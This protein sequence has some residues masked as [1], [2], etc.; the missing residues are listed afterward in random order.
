MSDN[1]NS[2]AHYARNGLQPIDVIEDWRLSFN[3][4]NALKYIMRAGHKDKSKLN[5]DYDKAIFYLKRSI[6]N[7]DRESTNVRG[8]TIA[9]NEV[10]FSWKDLS[11]KILQAVEIIYFLNGHISLYGYEQDATYAVQLI[12]ESKST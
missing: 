4:G 8:R 12:E 6:K 1:V 2:P 3:V 7:F 9:I 5:E 10:L 11:A